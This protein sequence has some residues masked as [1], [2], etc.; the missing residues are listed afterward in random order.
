[1]HTPDIIAHFKTPAPNL[2]GGDVGLHTVP[3][4]SGD[5]SFDKIVFITG[6]SIPRKLPIITP[7]V[8]GQKC[9]KNYLEDVVLKMHMKEF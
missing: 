3:C 9:R 5:T 8:E 7:R 4:S 1:M 6:P 2:V